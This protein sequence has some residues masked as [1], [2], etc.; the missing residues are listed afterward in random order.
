MLEK[1]KTQIEDYKNKIYEL[2]NIEETVKKRKKEIKE[3]IDILDGIIAEGAISNVNLRLLVNEIIVIE[4]E[5]GNL[6]II[7]SMNAPF[8][9]YGEVFD[10]NGNVKLRHNG[11]YKEISLQ[12]FSA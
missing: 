9:Q 5:D 12:E 2:K 6:A 1:K 8:D 11:N 10:E 4:M 3:S 7:V